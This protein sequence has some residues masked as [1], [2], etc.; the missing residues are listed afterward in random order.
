MLW[1]MKKKKI[2]YLFITIAL[3]ALWE[4]GHLFPAI[5]GGI[6]ILGMGYWI[7]AFF[8]WAFK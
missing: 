1:W 7:V 3:I 4:L 6:F 2:D 8:M 5:W